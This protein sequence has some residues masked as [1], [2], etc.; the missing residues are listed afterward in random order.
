MLTEEDDVE[1]HALARRGWSVSAIARHTGRDRKT[2]R[3]YLAAAAPSRE[4]AASCLEP[5]REYLAARLGD[6]AHVD[7]TVLFR[8]VCELGFDRSYVTFVRQVRLL[9]LRPR[10]EACRTG[11]HGVTVEL[12]HEPGEEIQWDWLELSETPWGEPAYVLVGVLSFSG[13]CRAVI[14]EGMSFAHLVDAIDGVLRRLGGTSRAWRTDR[15]ATV[16]YPGTDRVTAQF[17][18]V[19]KH[20]GVE[21]WVCPPRRPQRKGVVEKAIQYVTRSWW[22]TAPV[23]SLGQAQADLDRWAVAV[24]DRRKR[25]GVTIA[26]LAGREGLP[27][28]PALA[29]PAQLK[30]ERVVGRS[31][32]V[33]FE[34]NRYSVA[35][36]LVGQTVTVSARLGELHLEIL[37][38]AGRRVARH[39]RA[40][41]G[42]GQMLRSPEHARLLEQAVLDAFTTDKPCRRK[43]NRPP[44]DAALTAAARLRGH[45]ESTAVVVDLEDYAQIARVAR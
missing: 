35:P 40:P 39:R 12:G 15:M 27:G 32:L 34:G 41:A 33:A 11:G 9:G 3:R 8:E 7:G 22:R 14:S 16:V 38:A 21:V 44:S 25:R 20:Y 36:G 17:A 23:S 43:P 24:S 31:A 19:A 30:V 28:L 4:P 2:V 10:C 37:S 29:F 5:F 26:E 13:R 42:A 45:D 18:Q 6:D 1:I